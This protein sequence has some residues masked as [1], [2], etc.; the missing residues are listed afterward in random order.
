MKLEPNGVPN[1][2]A[3]YLM[4]LTAVS[5]L[6]SRNGDFILFLCFVTS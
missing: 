2:K 3:A 1:V 4:I 6:P 5:G